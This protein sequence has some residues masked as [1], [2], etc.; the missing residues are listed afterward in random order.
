MINSLLRNIQP[1]I[2]LLLISAIVVLTICAAYIYLFKK[3]FETY[4]L[5]QQSKMNMLMTDK[6]V[7]LLLE[8]VQLIENENNVFKA[9]IYGS[10]VSLPQNQMRAYVVEQ[11][12]AMAENHNVQLISV[13]P[14]KSN[15]VFMFEELPFNI[16]VRGKYTN[17]YNWLKEVELKLG[18]MVV[19]Q[20]EISTI[21]DDDI[22][23]M[24]LIMV[25]YQLQDMLK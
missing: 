21:D 24:K 13:I 23:Q 10:A 8:K 12:D 19:N 6:D 22:R 4:H 14:N 20:F 18:T 15:Q 3:P 9:K 16:E 1:R 5:Q 17:L 7:E 11:L 25:S 2:L